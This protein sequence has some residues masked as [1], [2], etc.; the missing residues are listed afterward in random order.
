MRYPVSNGRVVPVTELG[1]NIV[2]DE[3][4]YTSRH[5][6]YW[7]RS[8]YRERRH[9]QVF[10]NL[11]D[12]VVTMPSYQHNTLHD[13][14]DPPVRPKDSFMIDCVDEYLALHGVLD[15]VFESKTCISREISAE[16]WQQIR[17]NV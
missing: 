8:W 1:F 11:V 10:R 9:R 15:V 4:G 5:H 3:R 2:P 13:I 14:Y 16:Q 7:E 17:S 12:H 6:L